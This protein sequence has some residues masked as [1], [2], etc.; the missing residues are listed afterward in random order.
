[1]CEGRYVTWK[2]PGLECFS[3]LEAAKVCRRHREYSSLE[4][5]LVGMRRSHSDGGSEQCERLFSMESQSERL[6]VYRRIRRLLRLY[7]PVRLFRGMLNILFGSGSQLRISKMHLDFGSLCSGVV[8]HLL[9]SHRKAANK[10]FTT[11]VLVLAQGWLACFGCSEKSSKMHFGISAR[12]ST[13]T[14]SQETSCQV[15]RCLRTAFDLHC[16]PTVLCIYAPC[17]EFLRHGNI[18]R[19]ESL[20]LPHL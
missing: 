8:D 11:L 20:L 5:R 1:M 10:Y 12:P 9:S 7:E 4:D 2:F 16:C 3:A 6:D 15:D 18:V 19:A 14:V 17:R 13:T